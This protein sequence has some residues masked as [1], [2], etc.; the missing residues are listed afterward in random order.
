MIKANHD[1]NKFNWWHIHEYKQ[2]LFHD[3]IE[4]EC[5]SSLSS[6]YHFHNIFRAA[7]HGS[8]C[9][10]LQKSKH[11]KSWCLIKSFMSSTDHI[12][13]LRIWSLSECALFLP[14]PQVR[15]LFISHISIELSLAR[16]CWQCQALSGTHLKDWHKSKWKKRQQQLSFIFWFLEA[17]YLALYPASRILHSVWLHS[18]SLRIVVTQPCRPEAFGLLHTTKHRTKWISYWKVCG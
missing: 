14:L 11:S 15:H 2:G 1:H 4:S 6:Q 13:Q 5:A 8:T 10:P 12:L 7:L 3:S 17:C 16:M 9:S 18:L